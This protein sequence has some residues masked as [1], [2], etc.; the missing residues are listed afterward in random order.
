MIAYRRDN[1]G[2]QGGTVTKYLGYMYLTS[3]FRLRHTPA[4]I[5][6]RPDSPNRNV[7]FCAQEGL[8]TFTPEAFSKTIRFRRGSRS[9]EL[10]AYAGLNSYPQY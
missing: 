1:F 6:A 5:C 10:N 4:A 8:A 9:V 7:T 2:S 3:T